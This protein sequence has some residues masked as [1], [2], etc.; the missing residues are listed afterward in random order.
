MPAKWIP[1]ENNPE[2]LN[3]WANA[4]GLVETEN[5]FCEV[6]GLDP[7]LLALVPRPVKAVVLLYPGNIDVIA[8]KSKQEEEQIAT[9]GQ[10]PIDPS[11]IWVKQ[12]IS[13]ACGT[14]AVLHALCNSGAALVPE[15]PMKRYIKECKDK[16]PLERA[17]IL[18]E[19]PH[20][21][22]IHKTTAEAG[23]SSVPADLYVEFHFTCFV[24]APD[25]GAGA[26]VSSAKKWR[27][28]ELN[29][30]RNGP[31]D[32]G[33]S[34]DLLMDVANYVKEAYVAHVSSIHFSMMALAP[35]EL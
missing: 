28:L 10:Y 8:D 21:A 7:E 6:Y 11:V 22:E 27:L 34:D 29:G 9:G 5:Q 14:M 2:V 31:I 18:E 13:N 12:T 3:A 23:Q 35:P 1:L 25:V 30:A 24:Q 33:E 26:T 4:A 16:T 32:R 20:F 19:A 17:K 15:S